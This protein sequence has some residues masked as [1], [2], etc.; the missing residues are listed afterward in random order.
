MGRPYHVE[1][2]ELGATYERAVAS[3]SVG[4]LADALRLS[5][6]RTFIFIGSGGAHSAARFMAG[7][8]EHATKRPA[9][10]MTPLELIADP[11][12]A[13]GCCVVLVS[14]GGNNKDIVATFDAACHAEHSC[15]IVITASKTGTL[16]RRAG[17]RENCSC[18]VSPMG[19]AKD[20]FLAVNSLISFDALFAM[21]CSIA[22]GTAAIPTSFLE[23]QKTL[24]AE[25]LGVDAKLN[26]AIRYICV[27]FA[28]S[29]TAA[30]CDLESKCTEAGLTAVIPSDLRNFGHGRHHW[31]AKHGDETCV[32]ILTSESERK[33]GKKTGDLIPRK[34]GVTHWSFG[35]DY[36][37]VAISAQLAVLYFVGQL[38][39]HHGID[40]GRPGVPKFG[41]QL[42]SLGPKLLAYPA[43]ATSR[44]DCAVIRKT[45]ALGAGVLPRPTIHS[46]AI[47][48]LALLSERQ[49]SGLVLDYD[50]TIISPL[51]RYNSI[52]P[53]V[54][55]GLA[56]LL[57][58]SISLIVCTGRGKSAHEQLRMAVD[59]EHW[60]QVLVCMYNGAASCML[61]DDLGKK[62]WHMPEERLAQVSA[63][64]RNISSAIRASL[65]LF[66]LPFSLDE[67][68]TQVSI[69]CRGLSSDVVAQ[70]VQSRIGS[71]PQV[72]FKCLTSAHSADVLPIEI[73]KSLGAT[74][75]VRRGLVK[76]PANLL[77]IGDRPVWPGNDSEMLC[78]PAGLSVDCSSPHLDGGWNF[79]A[80]GLAHEA[81]LCDY[82]SCI[83][84]VDG[85]FSINL[86][87]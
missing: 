17:T 74:V 42:Y 16:A 64:L 2:Q 75:A 56:K 52:A 35:S 79:A 51:G 73:S 65:E 69:Q 19:G 61:S 44:I 6:D 47:Q 50:G 9:R 22:F 62:T 57:K 68:P 38:G 87:K 76:E 29:A 86:T 4:E 41:G 48:C 30:A 15:V 72:S 10:T 24:P 82:L 59:E 58:S 18:I 11:S 25:L 8:L 13:S 23:V 60:D 12:I 81:A 80:S 83:E 63:D 77:W 70:I 43:G 3:P 53:G 1:L 71:I 36:F 45:Q 31:I 7:G 54:S 20:G 33:L 39:R 14:A 66:G 5:A 28:P 67:K 49:F 26:K 85:S 37:F 84:P 46:A 34:T 27:L 40:P 78:Q 21:A 32:F 55:D